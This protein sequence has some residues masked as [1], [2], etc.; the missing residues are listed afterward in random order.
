MDGDQF[1]P[2]DGVCFVVTGCI[3]VCAS[4]RRRVD[5]RGADEGLAFL[6][7]AVRVYPVIGLVKGEPYYR[8]RGCGLS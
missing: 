4:V 1:R 8:T 6:Y 7:G 3:Y 5:N 2:H